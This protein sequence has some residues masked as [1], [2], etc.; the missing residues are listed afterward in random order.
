M[1]LAKDQMATEQQS[2]DGEISE[3]DDAVSDCVNRIHIRWV[4]TCSHLHV[5]KK[6]FLGSKCAVMSF[7]LRSTIN[8]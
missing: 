7:G 3:G 5:N 6:S 1:A 8:E 4:S 2:Q